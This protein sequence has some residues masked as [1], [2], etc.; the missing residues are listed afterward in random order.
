[1]FAGIGPFLVN[2]LAQVDAVLQHQVE[3]AAREWLCG[4]SGFLDSGIS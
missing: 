3:R 1:V 2:D 4:G